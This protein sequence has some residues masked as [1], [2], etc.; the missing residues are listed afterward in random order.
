M[1]GLVTRSVLGAGAFARGSPLRLLSV[2]A[3]AGWA[4]IVGLAWWLADRR[5][6]LCGLPEYNESCVLR[7]TAARDDIL[8]TG[9]TVALALAL[10]FSVI[11]FDRNRRSSSAPATTVRATYWQPDTWPEPFP[12]PLARRTT[13]TLP[14]LLGFGAA[15]LFGTAAG[16]GLFWWGGWSASGASDQMATAALVAPDENPYADLIPAETSAPAEQDVGE[17]PAASLEDEDDGTSVAGE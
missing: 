15:V 9:L 14:R 10:L 13:R 4:S 12:P 1:A 11:R 8:I 5:I 7:A 6:G 16:A 2:F 3:L 17:E